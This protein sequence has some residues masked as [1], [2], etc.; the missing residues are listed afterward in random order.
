[1]A[2]KFELKFSDAGTNDGRIDFTKKSRNFR[3]DSFKETKTS[4]A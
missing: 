4:R 3:F 1:M 2:L